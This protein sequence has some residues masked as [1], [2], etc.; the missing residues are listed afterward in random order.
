M[1]NELLRISSLSFFVIISY[2]TFPH[3]SSVLDNFFGKIF[4]SVFIHQLCIIVYTHQVRGVVIFSSGC[5]WS[6]LCVILKS[7]SIH[8]KK[9]PVY[10]SKKGGRWVKKGCVY[11]YR[12]YVYLYRC[13]GRSSPSVLRHSVFSFPLRQQAPLAPFVRVGWVG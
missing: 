5:H 8:Y 3:L 2:H 12:D 1:T 10:P 11:L 6:G 13:V 7:D 9:Y 4:R